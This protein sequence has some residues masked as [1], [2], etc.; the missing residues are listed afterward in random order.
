[1]LFGA[2]AVVERGVGMDKSLWR[3][4]CLL[5]DDFA[6][7]TP[8]LLRSAYVE[9][10]YRTYTNEFE[11]TRLRQSFWLNLITNVSISKSSDPLTDLFPPHTGESDPTFTRPSVPFRC[12]FYDDGGVHN[13]NRKDGRQQGCGAGTRRTPEEYC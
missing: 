13:L 11:F 6:S 3:L 2:V 12:D 7:I 10:I 8:S 4:P 1:M 5:V 9:A